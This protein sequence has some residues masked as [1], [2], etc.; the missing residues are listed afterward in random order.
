MSRATL[1]ELRGVLRGMVN[2]GTA[3]YTLGTASYWDDDQLDIVLDRYRDDF[4]YE[5]MEPEPIVGVGGTSLYYL[6]ELED[7][8]NIEQTS[9]GTSIFY[10]QDGTGATIGTASYTV[11]YL[12]GYVEFTQDTRG[13]NYF[14][15]GRTY[16][17]NAAAA[18]IWRKKAGY[19]H[20]AF[21]FSTDN[22]K[23]DR[24]A[25]YKHCVQMAES[26]ESMSQDSVTSIFVGRGDT[27]DL[28]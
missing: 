2:S 16:D 3:D 22:H 17:L 4:S 13:T 9:G 19:Y 26:F 6:Y 1:A 27:D 5:A 8:K 21:N 7:R 25:I 18:D 12:R 15:S 24:E 28:E 14:A 23:I 20:T 10:I 11:D